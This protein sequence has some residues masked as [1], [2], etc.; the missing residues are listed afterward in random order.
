MDG[1]RPKGVYRVE[2][3]ALEDPTANAATEVASAEQLA[4]LN[5]RPHSSPMIPPLQPP[6]QPP[7]SAR[8]VE[9]PLGQT[10]SMV[11]PRLQSVQPMPP[12]S[13]R[14]SSPMF[15][16]GTAPM[17]MP[18]SAVPVPPAHVQA[19]AQALAQQQPGAPMSWLAKILIFL[20]LFVVL[21]TT[22]GVI[23]YFYLR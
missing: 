10:V 22:A 17:P 2:Y 3:E 4:S 19:Q 20:A 14:Q 8:R 6:P 11:D 16:P 9:H 15:S 12:P 1:A 18:V 23:T 5:Q 13:V 21:T 7:P